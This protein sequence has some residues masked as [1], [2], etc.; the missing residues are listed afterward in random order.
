MKLTHVAFPW[1]LPIPGTHL[2]EMTFRDSDGW[3]IQL[4]PDGTFSLTKGPLFFLT[5]GIVTWVPA[6]AEPE[7]FEPPHVE[8]EP[9]PQYVKTEPKT[10]LRKKNGGK[11]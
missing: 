8:S 3:D 7:P 2:R 10:G 4:L 1:Q 6:P 5:D 11:S 9:P